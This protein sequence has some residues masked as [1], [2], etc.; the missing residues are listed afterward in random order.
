MSE[1]PLFFFATAVETARMGD[2]DACEEGGMENRSAAWRVSNHAAQ[3]RA[4]ARK[5]RGGVA[6]TVDQ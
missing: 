6:G 1:L 2:R 4:G 3:A 5:D